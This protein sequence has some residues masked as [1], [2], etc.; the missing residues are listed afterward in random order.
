MANPDASRVHY[1]PA[2]ACFADDLVAGIMTKVDDP[3]CMASAMIL[4]PNRRLTQAVRLA[5][6][7]Y[8]AGKPQILPRLM[9]IGDIDT[10]DA[11]LVVAG[12]DAGD[13]PPVIDPLERQFL[14][15]RL[16]HLF[17]HQKAEK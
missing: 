6:L 2:G 12:W 17:R 7:R 15:A 11:D 10:D 4:L 13:L 1:I 9:A 3:A 8:S 5:F 16:V 14:L